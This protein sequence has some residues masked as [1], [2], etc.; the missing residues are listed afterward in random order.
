MESNVK[1][2][3]ESENSCENTLK[4]L[5]TEDIA[6][7]DGYPPLIKSACYAYKSKHPDKSHSDIIDEVYEILE[8]VAKA[9]NTDDLAK[10]TVG[11]T[12]AEQ[13]DFDELS[14]DGK[15]SYCM[16]K[17][18]TPEKS[19]SEIRGELEKVGLICKRP[20]LPLQGIPCEKRYLGW[21]N[22]TFDTPKLT[23]WQKIK[24]FFD[25]KADDFI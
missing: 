3:M 19:H 13:V 17:T 15:I 22:D 1:Q 5:T 25:A 14:P 4:E 23:F 2:K 24:R 9:Y 11:M 16:H 12:V 10:Y 7:F 6:A 8:E 20:D 21:I 18:I